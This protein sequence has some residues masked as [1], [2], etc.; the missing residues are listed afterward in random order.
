MAITLPTPGESPWDSDLNNALFSLQ[1]QVTV[2]TTDYLSRVLADTLYAANND[3]RIT[4]ALNKTNNLSELTSPTTARTNLGLGNSA[5]LNVGTAAGTVSA[6]DA[7]PNHVAATDPHGDRAWA[8][9]TFLASVG[10]TLT[11]TLTIATGGLNVST[12]NFSVA[13]GTTALGGGVNVTGSAIVSGGNV[14]VYGASTASRVYA[15]AVGGDP[16]DRWHVLASGYM[17][18]SDGVAST[19][20]NLY[21]KAADQLATDDDFFIN[22]AGK[23]LNIKEG[24]NAK[25]GTAVLV[26]GQVIVSNTAVTATS[27]I[28]LTSQVDG[29]TPGFLR[30]SQRTAGA[31]FTIKSSSNTDTSTVAWVIVEP[32]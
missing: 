22:I 5:T 3:S 17:Q 24:T 2:I 8:T 18:W 16:I 9:A 32:A 13:S 21:R 19:D 1:Q 26:A 30:V 12:G 29:G 27:R 11:G 25:M 6:G 23:G 7:V 4:N 31:T 15:T 10:G 14:G 20:T 28:F